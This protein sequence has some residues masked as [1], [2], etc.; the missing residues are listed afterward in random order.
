MSMILLFVLLL[1]LLILC[2]GTSYRHIILTPQF[3][4]VGGFVLSVGYA[5][6]WVEE[7]N[8]ELSGTTFMVLF[9]GCSLF[10]IVSILVQKIGFKY[11]LIL[12]KGKLNQRESNCS[13]INKTDCQLSVE[14]WKLLLFLILQLIVLVC[15][16]YFLVFKV[17]GGLAGAM[18]AINGSS[19]GEEETIKF[20]FILRILRELCFASGFFWSYI[21]GHGVVYKYKNHRNLLL[22]NILLSVANYLLGGARRGLIQL[23][24]AILVMMY[25]MWAEKMNWSKNI[26]IK[27]ILKV[28]AL[29]LL[30]MLSY[31]YIGKLIGRQLSLGIG[32]YIATY[33]SAEIKNLDTFIKEGAFGQGG[34]FSTTQTFA[35]IANQFEGV[36]GL[37]SRAFKYDQP[38]RYINGYYLGNVY[39]TFWAFLYDAGFLG[40]VG[41][42]TLMAI[43]LQCIYQKAI[44]AKGKSNTIRIS[45]IAYSYLYLGAVFSFFTNWFY[46]IF[47]NRSLLYCLV[48]WLLL[49]FYVEKV[50]IRKHRG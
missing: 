14:Q 6:F 26:K 28:V 36:L 38:Y 27:T 15:C 3:G 49:K 4:F 40:V 1:L 34:G 39:T 21:M 9:G 35:H 29:A 22:F 44:K 18:R 25:L 50:K 33:I 37:P 47:F 17:G 24:I 43:I 48:F 20:P 16:S 2:R 19:K 45:M 5:L 10:V 41:Y 42:T 12:R 8:L 7:W 13:G 32:E 11:T 23:I 31:Q 30:V 46:A